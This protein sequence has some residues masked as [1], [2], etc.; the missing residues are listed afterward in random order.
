MERRAL[1]AQYDPEEPTRVLAMTLSGSNALTTR[2]V[3][4]NV[5]PAMGIDGWAHTCAPSLVTTG[6]CKVSLT[7][8]CRPGGHLRGPLDVPPLRL[9][10]MTRR[11]L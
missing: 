9:V 4:S 5:G 11:L 3:L 1:A 8:P 7:A 6:T 2:T 10:K